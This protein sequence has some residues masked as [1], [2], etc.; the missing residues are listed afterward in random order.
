[1]AAACSASTMP[2]ACQ[3]ASSRRSQPSCTAVA[4]RRWSCGVPVA[5]WRWSWPQ[6]GPPRWRAHEY[7]VPVPWS[8]RAIGGR[9]AVGRTS[10]GV[11][12]AL[13]GV[14]TA[15]GRVWLK[16]AYE[17]GDDE[18]GDRGRGGGR[19][20]TGRGWAWARALGAIAGAAAYGARELLTR[21]AAVARTRI[22]H[23]PLGRGR[24]RTRTRSGR[25]G[26]ATRSTCSCSATRSP[27]GSAPTR[28]ST[29][30][31]VAWPGAS[32]SAPG[33][34][35][36]CAPP[37]GSGRRAPSWRGRSPDSRRLPAPTSPSSWSAATT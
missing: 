10:T 24:R 7:E 32:P 21:Q 25:S 2:A 11:G 1:M 26:T 15:L 23:H 19:A 8:V 33:A 34:R 5:G 9:V 30:W 36:A 12:P 20:G 35:C 22:N 27:P 29:R 6:R 13:G 37:P 18:A 3:S 17:G 28:P 31:A 14:G 16:A 4:S